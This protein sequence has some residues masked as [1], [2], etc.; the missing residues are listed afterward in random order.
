VILS[1]DDRRVTAIADA[2]ARGD[3]TQWPPGTEDPSDEG[4]VLEQLRV[5]A[6]IAEYY[7]ARSAAGRLPAS[8]RT[9]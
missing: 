2:I 3:S 1:G 7:R 4:P 6:V 9:A 5:L 8:G